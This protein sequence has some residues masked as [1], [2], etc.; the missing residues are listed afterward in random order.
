MQ[1]KAK[2]DADGDAF[3]LDSSGDSSDDQSAGEAPAISARPAAA[4]AVTG[5]KRSH[6]E[7]TASQAQKSLLQQAQKGM[8]QQV[9]RAKALQA[10][11]NVGL[12]ADGATPLVGLHEQPPAKRQALAG[13]AHVKRAASNRMGTSSMADECGR[14]RTQQQ[15]GKDLLP[16]LQP[17]HH[18]VQH[19]AQAQPMHGSTSLAIASEKRDQ[20][21][22]G[23]D[24]GR[25]ESSQAVSAAKQV[26]V[27]VLSWPRQ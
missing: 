18:A 4:E 8:A 25:G 16:A 3:F 22:R 20:S 11:N 21:A 12:R 14:E 6:V 13:S 15:T 1:T 5:R 10:H 2:P 9:Q 23:D 19:S 24:L 7:I 17:S 27:L 26:T